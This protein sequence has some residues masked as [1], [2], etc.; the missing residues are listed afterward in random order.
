MR[1][2]RT[3][4]PSPSSKI[5]GEMMEVLR[6]LLPPWRPQISGKGY[7][8]RKKKRDKDF[9]AGEIMTRR[10]KPEERLNI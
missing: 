7:I 2:K 10:D 3:K 6:G 8:Q 9:R 5:S 4:D 1:S